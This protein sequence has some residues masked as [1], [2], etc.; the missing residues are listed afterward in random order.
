MYKLI[1][2]EIKIRRGAII[3]W[4]IGLAAFI[5]LYVTVYPTL[6]AE[7]Y[8]IPIEEIEFYRAIGVTSMAT[9]EGYLLSIVFNILPLLAGIFGI[10]LGVGVLAGEEDSGTLELLA[11]LPLSRVQLVLAKVVALAITVFLVMLIVGLIVMG[12]FM[13]I[14]DQIETTVTAT[15]MFMVTLIHWLITF[16]FATIGLFVGAYL[17]NRRAS[18]SVSFVLLVIAFFGNNL[19][20]MT[21]SLEPFQPLTPSYYFDNIVR[22]L[23]GE[24]AW[25]D[26]LVLLAMAVGFLLLALISF[27]KRNLTVGAWPW[28]RGKVPTS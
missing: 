27:Q 8:E 10:T 3:G 21:P 16:V 23:V 20:G 25:G 18:L 2:H 11:A 4:T 22:I 17:P 5:L 15:D 24:N 28:Q 19:A 7:Y 1:P 26:V 6:P 12:V 13:A 9:F 14:Q